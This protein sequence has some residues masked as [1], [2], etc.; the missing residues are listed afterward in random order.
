[1]V[2]ESDD[3]QIGIVPAVDLVANFTDLSGLVAALMTSPSCLQS[4]YGM[5]T[6]PA[7]LSV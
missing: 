5:F 6:D 2:K 7:N 4:W 3:N 1:M